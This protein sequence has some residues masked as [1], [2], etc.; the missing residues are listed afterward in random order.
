MAT[1]VVPKTARA[2]STPVPMPAGTEPPRVSQRQTR[3]TPASAAARHLRVLQ[4]EPLDG[5]EELL[6][7]RVR[8]RPAALDVVDAEVVETLGDA[9]LVLER[10]GDV[11]GLGAV[12]Q[13]RVVE[14]DAS[15]GRG[16]PMKASCSAR[17][18][19]SVYFSSITTEILISEVEIICTLMLSAASTS[20][21]RAAI[22]ACVRMPMPTIDTLATSVC[23]VTPCAPISLAVA[24]TSPRAFS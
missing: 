24:S 15:H 22:P 12:A 17:T 7:A 3:S 10:E 18:A 14:L 6:V 9:H 21:M 19:S 16:P 5:P 20:N 11:L 4:A 8:A 13:G 2:A 1:G 23:P